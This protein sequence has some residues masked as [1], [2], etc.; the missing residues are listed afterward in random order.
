M[1]HLGN[2]TGNDNRI[3]SQSLEILNLV[4][5]N[6]DL[7]ISIY[8]ISSQEMLFVNTTLAKELSS[9]KDKIL[10][11]H[12]KCNQVLRNIIHGSCDNCPRKSILRREGSLLNVCHNWESENKKTKKWFFVRNSVINWIDGREVLIETATDI[13]RQ[14]RYELQLQMIASKDMMTDT[15][16]RDWGARIINGLI[17]HSTEVHSLT[18]IDLDC[19]KHV[20]DY[21][22][23]DSG[24]FFIIKTVE[25]IKS[26]IRKDDSLS[27]WGGDEFILITHGGETAAQTVIKRIKNKLKKYNALKERPFELEFSYGIV[28]ICP[29]NQLTFDELITRADTKMYEN[30]MTKQAYQN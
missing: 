3:L 6:P 4:V 29:D 17:Q 23:H 24:D 16:N 19:L 14:K 12:K 25:V 10:G 9:N 11:K 22:G 8:D 7:Y 27:R 15:Y 2:P 20:N 5:D 26:C 1:T 28:E 18:F 30:K 21:Y 13:T